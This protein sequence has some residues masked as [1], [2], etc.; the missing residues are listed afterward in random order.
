MKINH[1]LQKGIGMV[2]IIVCIAIITI[3][4]WGFL[5]LTKYNLRIQ[6]Q[7]EAKMETINLAAEAIEAVRSVRDENWN[8]LSSLSLGIKYYPVISANK[9][10]LTLTDPGP[11]IGPYNRWVI[12]EKVFRDNNDDISAGGAEDTQTK[13]I[14]AFVEWIDQTGTKQTHLTTYLTNWTD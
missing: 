10:T 1:Q 2:E 13:K 5:E 8:N 12:L 9:W 3:A 7:N 11:I 6:E 4:F 14:T